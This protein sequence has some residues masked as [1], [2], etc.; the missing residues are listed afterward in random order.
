MIQ[1]FDK[2]LEILENLNYDQMNLQSLKFLI[3]KLDEI[4]FPDPDNFEPEPEEPR[5][6]LCRKNALEYI[7]Y[8]CAMIVISH[9]SS[10]SAW[11]KQSISKKQRFVRAQIE[12]EVQKIEAVIE[13]ILNGN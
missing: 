6:P 8:L 11:E 9:S 10:S 3:G 5:D 12:R 4:Q 13:D 7:D 1:I 2:L